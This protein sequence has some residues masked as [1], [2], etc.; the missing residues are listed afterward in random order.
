MV[1]ILTFDFNQIK[2][3]TA[4]KIFFLMF[5]FNKTILITND[6]IDNWSK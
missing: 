5:S 6:I 2:S 1:K 3:Q 4:G